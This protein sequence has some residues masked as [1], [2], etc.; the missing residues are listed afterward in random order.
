M[1]MKEVK[2]GEGNFARFKDDRE[3]IELA[4]S[5]V[6]VIS[7]SRVRPFGSVVR[8]NDLRRFIRDK[9]LSLNGYSL[10]IYACMR[11]IVQIYG[12]VLLKEDGYIQMFLD[13]IGKGQQAVDMAKGYAA[14]NDLFPHM[15]NVV[16][17]IVLPKAHLAKTV[18]PLQAADFIAWECRKNVEEYHGWFESRNDGR[19]GDQYTRLDWAK[20]NHKRVPFHR[21]S[22]EQFMLRTDTLL[23]CWTYDM[24]AMENE[25]RNGVWSSAAQSRRA[26]AQRSS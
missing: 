16:L 4:K 5:I 25:F 22:M 19:W 15:S 2:S 17:P 21:K 18:L 1:H 3:S 10:N 9:A 23:W 6:A 26:S 24:L 20:E 14:T 12:R 8:I 11:L 13:R 7:N